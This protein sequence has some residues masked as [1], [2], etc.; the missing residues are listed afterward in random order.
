MIRAKANHDAALGKL[1]GV[2]SAAAGANDSLY[3]K[4][5]VYWGR[6]VS[7]PFD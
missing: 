4:N 3:Q 2:T 7:L 5:Y 6:E 1:E